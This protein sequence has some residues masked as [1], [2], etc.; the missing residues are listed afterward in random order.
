MTEFESL[1]RT[2]LERLAPLPEGSRLDWADVRDRAELGRPRQRRRIV[3]VLVAAAVCALLLLLAAPALGIRPLGAVFGDEPTPT[4]TWPEGV[5]GEPITPPKLLV[6]MNEM[7]NGRWADPV[8]IQTVRQIV[9]AGSGNA[10]GAFYAARGLNGDVCLTKLGGG[11]NFGTPFS[12]LHDPARKGMPTMDSRA[13]VTG[14]ASGG[15]RGSVVDYATLIGVVRADVGRVELTLANGQTIEL[16]LNRWRGFGYAATDPSRFPK[17]LS[18]YR[19]WSSFFRR[20]QKLVGQ[21]PLQ[22]LGGLEPTPLCGGSYG[23]CPEG[24]KP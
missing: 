6:S 5:P 4:W 1:L 22:Q 20:H 3:T 21:L 2:R 11:G 23:P 24:V 19:S 18:V 13:M 7:A 10:E 12:C 16:P 8:D 17:T 14:M 15:H 9:T